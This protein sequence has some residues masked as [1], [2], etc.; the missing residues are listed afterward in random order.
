MSQPAK[1]PAEKGPRPEEPSRREL[2]YGLLQS[3]D[4][5]LSIAEISR[6]G[7]VHPNTVRFH[8][9]ALTALGRVEQIENLARTPGRPA[10]LFRAVIGMDPAGPRRYRLLAEI[11]VAG[12]LES[13]NPRESAIAAGRAWTSQQE[14]PSTAPESGDAASEGHDPTGGLMH[15]MGDLGFAPELRHDEAG[16]SRTE[17]HLRHCPFLE[18]VK[19]AADVV[20]PLHLGLMQGALQNWGSTIQA[21]SLQPFVEPDRCVAQLSQAASAR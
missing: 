7:D 20:C 21:T 6:R 13:S 2:V 12:L 15:L 11:L 10:L 17:L 1:S 8:L 9:N 18:L 5:P 4:E 16:D 3:A 14:Q 19:T